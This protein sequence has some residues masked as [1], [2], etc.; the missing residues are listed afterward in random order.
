MIDSNIMGNII[1]LYFGSVLFNL[2]VIGIFLG[3]KNKVEQKLELLT[4]D[5][6]LNLRKQI[7]DYAILLHSDAKKESDSIYSD[8]KK[9]MKPYELIADMK[10]KYQITKNKNSI[11]FQLFYNFVYF[12]LAGVLIFAINFTEEIVI[13]SI[14][15]II[16]FFIITPVFYNI[17]NAFTTIINQEK[18]INEIDNL[19]K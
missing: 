6:E 7:S 1:N 5:W 17:I 4:F 3:I 10:L 15:V 16:L 2:S 19:L 11:V 18:N 8:L 9:I 13:T 12:L 14:F